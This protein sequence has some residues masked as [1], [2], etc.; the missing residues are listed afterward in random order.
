MPAPR[1]KPKKL[2]P[3]RSATP[4]RRAIWKIVDG[5]VRDALFEHPEYLRSGARELTVRRSI[6]KRVVG[7]LAGY[8][9]EKGLAS[10]QAPDE[11]RSG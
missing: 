3:L 9:G 10:S 2:R 11:G 8:V 4:F 7:A 5:A 6:N 1:L